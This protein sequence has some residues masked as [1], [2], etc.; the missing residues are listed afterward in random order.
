MQ[1]YTIRF[2][3]STNDDDI[4]RVIF[5]DQ[6][7]T[8]SLG[9]GISI[10]Y[11]NRENDRINMFIEITDESIKEYRKEMVFD[12]ISNIIASWIVYRLTGKPVRLE[13]NGIELPVKKVIIRN[14][15][16]KELQKSTLLQ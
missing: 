4:L 14:T 7:N 6:V 13:L 3:I 12:V 8:V 10:T 2:T 1:K 16:E 5:N 11:E 15:V 9:A